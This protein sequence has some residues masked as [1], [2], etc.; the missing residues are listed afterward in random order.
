MDAG[1]VE[2]HTILIMKCL[3]QIDSLDET[4]ALRIVGTK[5]RPRKGPYVALSYCWG[6]ARFLR[7][8]KSNESNLKQGVK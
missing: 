4:V 3:L 2:V 1:Q 7:L 5:I 6:P 8:L